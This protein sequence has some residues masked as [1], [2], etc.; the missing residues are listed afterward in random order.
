MID[1]VSKFQSI[2]IGDDVDFE[3]R[4]VEQDVKVMPVED[5]ARPRE[6]RPEFGEGFEDRG[7]E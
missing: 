1:S 2:K 3:A 6:E 4:A 5:E 7:E